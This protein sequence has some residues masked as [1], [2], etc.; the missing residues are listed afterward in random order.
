MLINP[1]K[2]YLNKQMKVSEV[3]DYFKDF[4]D[5]DLLQL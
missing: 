2:T 5:N 3:L 4:Y 1:E